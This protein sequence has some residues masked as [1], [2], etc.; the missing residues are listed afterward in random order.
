LTGGQNSFG[1]EGAED[2]QKCGENDDKD[3]NI[4]SAKV[5]LLTLQRGDKESE[6]GSL[7]KKRAGTAGSG[8]QGGEARNKREIRQTSPTR[9]RGNGASTKREELEKK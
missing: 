5:S 9:L 4:K 2:F 1:E 8:S 6:T 3:Q 7:K